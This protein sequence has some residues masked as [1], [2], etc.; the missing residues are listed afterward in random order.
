MNQKLTNNEIN[1]TTIWTKH[2]LKMSQKWTK[3]GP[4]MSLN[5]SK[6]EIGRHLED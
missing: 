5:G 4:K 2:G 6:M 3:S 1:L